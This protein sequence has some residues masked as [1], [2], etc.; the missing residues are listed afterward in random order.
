MNEPRIHQTGQPDPSPHF[1]STPDSSPKRIE[2]Q[3]G[4]SQNPGRDEAACVAFQAQMPEWIG[5][6]EDLQTHPHMLTCERC[7]ALVHDLEAIA[8][9]ARKLYHFEVEPPDDVWDQIQLALE[10]KQA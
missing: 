2:E 8:E 5:A 7:R 1:D 9:A 3:P 4:Q 10:R 6:G